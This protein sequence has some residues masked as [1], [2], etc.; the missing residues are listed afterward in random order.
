MDD[1]GEHVYDVKFSFDVS[2]APKDG[3]QLL[4]LWEYPELPEPMRS[5]LRQVVLVVVHWDNNRMV[6]WEDW[7]SNRANF[8]H[9][10][11][12]DHAGFCVW[13]LLECVQAGCRMRL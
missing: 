8:C 13:V 10:G 11:S 12:F 6:T 9:R 4:A 7:T 1:I 2:L 3:R 5:K